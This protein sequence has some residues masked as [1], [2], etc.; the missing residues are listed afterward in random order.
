M[1]ANMFHPFVPTGRTREFLTTKTALAPLGWLAFFMPA[2]GANALKA[3]FEGGFHGPRGL[4][5]SYPEPWSVHAPLVLC[6]EVFAIEVVVYAAL[7]KTTSWAII[8]VIDGDISVVLGTGWF[9]VADV[10]AVESQLQV[11]RSDVTLPLVLRRE[12]AFTSVVRET[13]YKNPFGRRVS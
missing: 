5:T 13:A 4:G 2:A 3:C 8:I 9:A 7:L 11:L 12:R 1:L 6:E 10:A